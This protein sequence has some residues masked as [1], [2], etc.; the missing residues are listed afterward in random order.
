MTLRLHIYGV[1]SSQ[2]INK[3]LR[4]EVQGSKAGNLLSSPSDGPRP[5]WKPSFRIDCS[6]QDNLNFILY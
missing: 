5:E 4:I 2:L 6:D 1:N 3:K